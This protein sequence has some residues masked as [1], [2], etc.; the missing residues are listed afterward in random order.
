MPFPHQ[1]S[2]PKVMKM[3]LL[4]EKAQSSYDAPFKAML[5]KVDEGELRA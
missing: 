4:L 3:K 5:V 1:L 2:E